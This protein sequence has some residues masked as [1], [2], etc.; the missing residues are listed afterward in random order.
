MDDSI[1]FLIFAFDHLFQDTIGSI[2]EIHKEIEVMAQNIFY[3]RQS[4]GREL[5][6]LNGIFIKQFQLLIS[7]ILTMH[8][9]KFQVSF[10]GHK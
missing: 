3:F 4:L 5:K 10:I 7:E 9:N 2:V 8:R 1:V 6:E